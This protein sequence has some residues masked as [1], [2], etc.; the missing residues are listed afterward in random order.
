MPVAP[1]ESAPALKST[2]SWCSAPPSDGAALACFGCENH[3]SRCSAMCDLG[4]GVP[5]TVDVILKQ[6]RRNWGPGRLSRVAPECFQSDRGRARS[7]RRCPR[8][9]SGPLAQSYFTSTLAFAASATMR[10]ARRSSIFG[11][12]AA[13]RVASLSSSLRQAATCSGVAESQMMISFLVPGAA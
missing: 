11:S 4:D 12:S 9:V 7:L 1:S 2:M 6:V 13:Q 5:H 3:S 8:G 10:V